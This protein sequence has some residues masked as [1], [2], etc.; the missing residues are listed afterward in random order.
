MS[1]ELRR[2]PH[3]RHIPSLKR[4]SIVPRQLHANSS[5]DHV[6]NAANA[7]SSDSLCFFR[8]DSLQ[9]ASTAW[10]NVQMLE[11]STKNGHESKH[12]EVK[13]VQCDAA[14]VQR[15]SHFG[16]HVNFTPQFHYT[17]RELDPYRFVGD[18]EMDSLL[19]YLANSGEC[20]CSAFDDV[21]AYCANA[22]KL[23]ACR[24][25]NPFEHKHKPAQA[26]P[27]VQFYNH[28]ATP[29]PWAN[30]EQIQRGIDVFLAYLP[31]AGCALYYRSLVGGFS[32]PKS[33]EVL[34]ATR[35]LV[36][37]SMRR[38][39]DVRGDV[40]GSCHARDE[41]KWNHEKGN[42]KEQRCSDDDRK[43]TLE[44]L[45][46]TGGFMACCFAPPEDAGNTVPA[47]SLRPGGK[48]WEAALR[49]RVLHAKV[50]RSLLQTTMRTTGGWDVMT[51]GIP[52]NQEDMAA[53]L[54]AFSVN[55]LLGIEFVAGKPLREEDQRDYLALWRYIG[56]LL[57]I[58]TPEWEGS[59][60]PKTDGERLPPIDPCGPSKHLPGKH[61]QQAA[62]V[63]DPILHS[64][65]TLESM[66]LHL[67]HPTKE[68][69]QLV[70]HLLSFKGRVE[71]RS[72]MCRKFLGDPLSDNLGIAQR[73]SVGTKCLV[74]FFLLFLRC[75]T[76]LAMT[77]PIIRRIL[78]PW[79]GSLQRRFLTRWEADHAKRVVVAMGEVT[80]KGS[81]LK[82]TC[83]FSMLMPPVDGQS[84][85]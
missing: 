29:P 43:R 41:A 51:N 59:S 75:Y 10:R 60:N 64:Y 47:L 37:G 72:E 79:H 14:S 2:R 50:R 11:C 73:S 26:L 17:K 33:V 22:Y 55:V 1:T 82:G 6:V 78:I 35:Y 52:I 28:F 81:G 49:V 70:S 23:H 34:V 69:R 19:E 24:E 76:L 62:L 46:D 65:A 48:G 61:E 30:F 13:E 31:A 42:E 40:E 67:L 8:F 25:D 57:G 84:K 21:I 20:A 58:D 27:P 54:L 3:P 56:W 66:I 80:E 15:I 45:L 85:K 39:V 68:S 83:P 63:E 16:S 38:K 32:I 53:T 7:V 77:F 18:A 36:P 71:F 12:D 5:E 74:Y 44:R 4:C 9:F